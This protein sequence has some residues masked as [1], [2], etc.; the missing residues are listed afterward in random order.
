MFGGLIDNTVSESLGGKGMRRN[1]EWVRAIRRR[2]AFKVC[3][4]PCD[5]LPVPGKEKR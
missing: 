5:T 3:P 2:G 4:T 1:L